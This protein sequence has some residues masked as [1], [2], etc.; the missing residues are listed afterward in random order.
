MSL[1]YMFQ[2]EW[3]QARLPEFVLQVRQK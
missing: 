2:P 1:T 3:E